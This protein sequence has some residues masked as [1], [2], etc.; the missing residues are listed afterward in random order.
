MENP[1]ITALRNVIHAIP[2]VTMR[3]RI[4]KGCATFFIDQLMDHPQHPVGND[5][6]RSI[7]RAFDPNDKTIGIIH[8]NIYSYVGIPGVTKKDLDTI[9]SWVFSEIERIDG[10]PPAV[11][12]RRSRKSRRSR[13]T[14]RYHK[15]SHRKSRR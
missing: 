10:P 1:V 7:L 11:G 9:L 3:D 14:R 4:T 6:L 15:R 5:T 12:G 8:C 13:R 2:Q